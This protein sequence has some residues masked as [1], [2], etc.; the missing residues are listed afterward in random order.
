MPCR[1][2]GHACPQPPSVRAKR[3]GFAVSVALIVVVGGATAAQAQAWLAPAGTGGVTVATQRIN[4]EGH[5]LGDGTLIADGKSE[6]ISVY[7]EAE[8][9]VTDRLSVSAGVPYVF[10]KF[11][12]PHPPPPPLPYLPIDQCRCWNH[13]WQDVELKVRYNAWLLH[14]R[15]FALTPLLAVG[16]P[17]HDYGFRGEAALGRHLR[18][19]R[20]GAAV[21]QRLD[22]LS[23]KLSLQME[24]T[25]ARV[26]RVLDLRNDRS[27]TSAG[28]AWEATRALS[29]R[30]DLSWQRTHGGLTTGTPATFPGQVDTTDRL[31]EHDRLLR[32]NSLHAEVTG[33]YHFVQCDVFASYVA[34]VRGT[35]T[36][37]G[38]AITVGISV[39]F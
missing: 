6:N 30:G 29:L 24:Y 23:P 27:N 14:G 20:A 25:F 19:V 34:F 35:D 9:A 28:L 32:D 38:R 5:R 3:D 36:H 11:I 22:V 17:S 26:E 4:Q 2:G 31:F 39:P 10:G 33:S 8:Y 12:G 1:S 7:V 37:A 15:T 18:E 21:G 16:L 13:G